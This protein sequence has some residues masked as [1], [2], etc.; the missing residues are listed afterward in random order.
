[1]ANDFTQD[2]SCQALWRFESG[3]LSVD[4]KN[5]NNLT[6]SN[7]QSNVSTYKEGG[8]CADFEKDNSAYC[9]IADGSLSA[10]FPLKNGDSTKTGAIA[11]WIRP[12]SALAEGLICGKYDTDNNKRSLGV[13]LT[14]SSRLRIYW[15]YNGGA[16][17]EY[18]D[19]PVTIS[20][21][22]F[23]HVVVSFDGV[24]KKLAAFVWDDTNSIF[25]AYKFSPAN[26]LN[27]ADCDWT[28]ARK[29]GATPWYYDGL[30]DELVVFNSPQNPFEANLLRAGNYTG[31]NNLVVTNVQALAEYTKA[32]KQRVTQIIAQVAYQLTDP[33]THNYYGHIDTAVAVSS[34][35]NTEI[36]RNGNVTVEITTSCNSL[37]QPPG[38]FVYDG[39][40]DIGVTVEGASIH[41]RVYTGN[42]PVTVTP[43]GS[44]WFATRA[45]IGNIE[46]AIEPSCGV[47]IPVTGF[48]RDTGYGIIDISFLSNDPP[49][50]VSEGNL[51]IALDNTASKFVLYAERS[52]AASGG[53]K[54]GGAGLVAMREPDLDEIVAEGGLEVS[55]G[56]PDYGDSVY[57]FITPE[58]DEDLQ[59][60]VVGSGGLV[61]SGPVL[62]VVTFVET[63]P[64]A[65]PTR[66]VVASGGVELGGGQSYA[67]AQAL[68][69]DIVASGG[70][71][72]SGPF[73][74]T[75]ELVDADDLVLA[76]CT[77]PV[78]LAIS[79]APIVTFFTPETT[80]TSWQEV[81]LVPIDYDGLIKIGGEAL[82][83][84]VAP[85]T[86]AI[87]ADG[88]L[89]V[90][91]GLSETAAGE[92][93]A[94]TGTK[95]EPSLYLNFVFNSY[96]VHNGVAY[97][98][99]D[100][101]IYILEGT[102]DN[103]APIHPGVRLGPTNFGSNGYK[104]IR[105]MIL[106]ESGDDTKV[107]YRAMD[108]DKE[109]YVEKDRDKFAGAR[110]VL[111]RELMVE[112]MDFDRLGA[113]N[114][115]VV[116]LARR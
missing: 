75:I 28:I 42:V 91:G 99:K 32:P 115:S 80:H 70:V 30:I 73:S 59:R 63:D 108:T 60:D 67:F 112:I 72:V 96:A 23:Y 38:Q 93:W 45:Y 48:D 37:Y 7:V 27:V 46:I 56:S 81:A 55:G 13:S 21:T 71:V 100:D 97:G 12:E 87:V 10:N 43:G 66:N 64:A 39:D 95:R 79:G 74:P 114:I 109:F 15:G 84:M 105:S 104:F 51:E 35:R 78:E 47:R 102:T 24:N 86:V 98:A 89:V 50:W 18:F 106:E 54:V 103:G 83:A 22:K 19:I 61:F 14:T 34:T 44:S 76:A 94:A 1:M 25:Y 8:G 31:A 92:T 16:S 33:N 116:P 111:G 69:R 62:P 41:N 53:V 57:E 17:Q 110:E 5:S 101:G 20:A 36:A 2:G 107:R 29:P 40:I 26:E 6:L 82:V 85:V 90:G 3:Y 68:Q 52:M 11:F 65:I 88:G 77:S 4:S 113:C 9:S 49:F 58:E